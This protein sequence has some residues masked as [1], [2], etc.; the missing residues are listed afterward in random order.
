MGS[1]TRI[2]TSENQL[3]PA[4]QEVLLD[5][6]SAGW[7]DPSKLHRPSRHLA[8]LLAAA[9]ETF[10]V[11]LQLPSD[12]IYFLGE[13]ALGFH[14]GINGFPIRGMTY[15]PTTSRQELFAATSHREAESIPVTLDSDWEVPAGGPEDLLAL[16]TVNLETGALSPDISNFQGFIF[17]DATATPLVEIPQNWSTAL[18]D[19]STWSGPRGLGVFGLKNP[20]SWKNPLPHI[21][22][23]TV[24]DGANPALILASAVAL[25]ATVAEVMLN[26]EKISRI[27]LKI[28]NFLT[29]E[30]GEVDIASPATAVS[31]RLSFSFLYVQ[32]E[33]LLEE[34]E[35]R[36]F[37]LDSGSACISANL[38]PSHV[39]AAMGRLT[40]G[41]IRLHLYPDLLE[42]TVDNFLRHLKESVE[43]QRSAR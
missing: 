9:R 15:L 33:Q 23:R 28:R 22:T 2:F 24:P 31:D 40:H 21:D 8:Q 6:F 38:E 10:S 14:L 7:A 16:S 12:S 3:H 11:H 25:D 42:E 37:S 4:A 41:N 32:A 26:A 17:I 18:W 27:N 30:I 34:M 35:R 29:S 19:S 1:I 13:P 36:G 20:K 39:L 5:A 43:I